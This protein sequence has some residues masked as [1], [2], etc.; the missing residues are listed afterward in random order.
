MKLQFFVPILIV[1]AFA[2]IIF[3][4]VYFSKKNIILRN[5]SRFKT[6]RIS[7]FK[8]NELTK[9]SGKVLEVQSPFIAP[10]SKRKCVAYIFE[11][12]QRVKSGK[13]SRW[14]TLVRRE[15]IQGFFI[16]KGGELVMV[17][18]SMEKSNFYSY[19]V[20]DKEVSSGTFND[21]TPE[22]QRVL[23]LYGLESE[24]WFGFNKTLKYTERIIEI[25]EVITIGGI[26]KWK[27]MD[28]PING[29]NYSKIATL[30]SDDNQKIII[31]DHPKA[32]TLKER[33]F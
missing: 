18:P 9:V 1:S 19:M 25:G 4:F 17:R 15:D 10:I 11:I 16:E 26:A 20:E 3:L 33:R 6:K 29:Y 22:F 7:Q 23:D 28:A 27:T 31:T 8:T 21:P 32:I 12:K 13:S 30:E 14:D 24:N 2:L 5:L